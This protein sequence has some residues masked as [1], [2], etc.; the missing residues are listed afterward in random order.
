M[1]SGHLIYRGNPGRRTPALVSQEV[2]G[3]V[4]NTKGKGQVEGGLAL[5][6]TKE[7][8]VIVG[9]TATCCVSCY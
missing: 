8:S 6:G 2:L 7:V 5:S 4:P 3:I 9:A 1:S